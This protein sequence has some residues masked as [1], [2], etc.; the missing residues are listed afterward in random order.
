MARIGKVKITKSRQISAVHFHRSSPSRH[1]YILPG[2]TLA[3]ALKALQGLENSESCTVFIG[4]LQKLLAPSGMMMMM[5][6]MVVVVVV[7]MTMMTMT[8]TMTMTMMMTTTTTTMDDDDDDDDLIVLN[9]ADL[10]STLM[11]PKCARQPVRAKHTI[12]IMKSMV[13]PSERLCTAQICAG[14]NI[15]T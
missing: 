11:F 10:G 14:A 13:P 8:M 2:P 6:M 9:Q 3:P 4:C 5:M 12:L 1:M 15:H 7:M